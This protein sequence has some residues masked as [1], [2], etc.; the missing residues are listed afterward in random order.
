M[1]TRLRA[2]E[3]KIKQHPFI[4][5]GIVVA[6][7]A[8]IAFMLAVHTFG[9]D[10]TGF[11]G[12][13]SKITVA[14]TS[15]GITTAKELQPAKSLWDWLGLLA[16]LAIPLVVG[17]GAAWYTAQ[18][19]KVSDREKTDN[20]RE[21]ALQAY[22]D[23]MTELMLKRRDGLTALTPPSSA[24]NIAR[25]RTLTVLRGLD[26]E[27]R[28]TLLR[29]LYE[30][31]LIEREQTVIQ[32]H[33]ADLSG[34]VL[35]EVLLQKAHLEHVNLSHADL[36]ESDL[37]GSSL[38]EAN[39]SE[40]N[41][42]GAKLAQ[43]DFG[44]ADLSFADLTGAEECTYDQLLQAALWPGIKPSDLENHLH[45][46]TAR[47]E[48]PPDLKQWLR[49]TP[50][51]H[52][53]DPI[54]HEQTVEYH[55]NEK[56]AYGR[57]VV[58][59][60]THKIEPLERFR[61]GIYLVTNDLFFRFVRADGY[62]SDR[63]W[64]S[65]PPQSR[66]RFVGQD[67]ISLAPSTW[68]SNTGFPKGRDRHP[69]TGISYYEA[70]AFCEWLQEVYP[71]D[72]GWN[73]SLPTENMWE[74]VARPEPDF[75]YPWG[76]KFMDGLCNSVEAGVGTTT[77]VDRFQNGKSRTGGCFDMAGNAWEFVRAK[78]DSNWSC[79][80]RGG[81][82]RNNEHEVKSSLRLYGVPRDHR[83]PDFGFRCALVYGKH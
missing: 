30:A 60:G 17:L 68:S 46:Q 37:R 4:T 58:T 73:W 14:S 34:A 79:V 16:T 67:G 33:G 49:T 52:V 53:T 15:K 51:L 7:L 22:F 32:I 83:P 77:E 41:L 70:L 8:I 21:T 63:F 62:K 44:G 81:S 42:R 11:T 78:D 43:V 48:L 61:L 36:S 75:L 40:A 65:T 10:W 69:V 18:Q 24:Q 29:F 56:E 9:W 5:V 27:R 54:S 26:G 2:W 28:A 31:H 50:W 39:L 82:F 6:L 55:D 74:L 80:L 35:S 45:K 13:E 66:G 25:Y 38:F 71:P 47:P 72:Y 1:I 19:G 23:D 20:Q 64:K 76:P 12:G 57:W 3:Q 59:R